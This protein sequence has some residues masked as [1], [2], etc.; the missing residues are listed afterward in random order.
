MLSA[1]GLTTPEFQLTSD[2]TVALQM[3]FLQAAFLSTGNTNG[4]TSFRNNGSI[5]MDLGPWLTTNY[6]ANAGIPSLVDGLNTLL[7]GGGLAAGAKT[8]IV[9]YVGNTTNFPY[10]T[11]PTYS[12]MRDRVRGAV[13]LVVTSPDFTVQK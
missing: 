8:A 4:L 11:P 3:N 1:A 12:Q 10:S 5:V 9:N 13:H 2:T 7:L 6:T